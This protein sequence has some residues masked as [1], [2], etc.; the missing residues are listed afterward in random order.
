MSLLSVISAE[1]AARGPMPMDRYMALC[2]GHPRHGYYMTR[3]P[4][5]EG[6]DFTTAPEISQIFGEML[7]LALAQIWIDQGRPAR[8]VLAEAGP[9]RGTL[10]ADILRVGRSVPGFTAAAEVA[11]IETSPVLQAIQAKTL[12]GQDVHWCRALDDLPQG[13][14]LL[15]ANEFFDAL[16][17]RQYQRVDDIWLERCVAATGPDD[18]LTITLRPAP[19]PPEPPLPLPDGAIWEECPAGQDIAARIG[20]RIATT[21]GAALILDYG[22]RDGDGDTLQAVQN[23]ATADVL[24]APGTADLTAH[25]RFDDLITAAEPAMAA[26]TAQGPFLERLGITARANA[27]LAAGDQ[28]VVAA[29]RR[30]THPDEMG[31]LF[32][33][34]GL[35]P[36]GAPPLPGFEP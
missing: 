36:L 19:N 4:L 17:V 23:H 13:P 29:H 16:P 20:T 15:V 8:F 30:L 18:R 21:G 11:L 33:V 35:C 32:K 22:D 3:D 27:L 28:A 25:V 5:G 1:I 31:Q 24:S 6:G 2:L 26:F 10:M 7:G 14:L 34:L 12:A 9:G